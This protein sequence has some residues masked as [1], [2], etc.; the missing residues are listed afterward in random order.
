MDYLR[1]QNIVLNYD[2]KNVK[3][4]V[5][6]LLERVAVQIGIAETLKTLEI[7]SI[8][9]WEDDIGKLVCA[10]FDEAVTIEEIIHNIIYQKM[11]SKDSLELKNPKINRNEKYLTKTS[12]DSCEKENSIPPNSILIDISDSNKAVSE[13]PNTF[14]EIIGRYQFLQKNMDLIFSF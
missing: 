2:L 11:H 10:Y 3:K 5:Q 1:I 12:F 9:I 6:N 13:D 7:E 8:C 14:L 4:S